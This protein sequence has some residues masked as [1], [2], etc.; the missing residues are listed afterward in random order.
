M[1][2]LT[3]VTNFAFVLSVYDYKDVDDN[4]PS[5]D[6][7]GIGYTV[8][9]WQ[10]DRFVPTGEFYE[11]EREADNAAKEAHNRLC[12]EYGLPKVSPYTVQPYRFE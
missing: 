4:S 2:K 9:I 7:F 12:D 8:H 5:V 11:V 10:V 1:A 6:K 3:L